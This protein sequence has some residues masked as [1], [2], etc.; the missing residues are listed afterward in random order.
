MPNRVF[1][2]MSGGVDSSVAA[3]LLLQA[4]YDVTGATMTLYRP[5]GETGDTSDVIDARAV[6]TRLGIPHR[7]YDMGDAFCHHVI[8]DFI[9]TYEDGGTP[10]PCVTCNRTIKFGALWE[11]VSEDGANAIATGRPDIGDPYHRSDQQNRHRCGNS[12]KPIFIFL[13]FAAFHYNRQS[14]LKN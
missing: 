10:N 14:I 1:A 7:T 5:H 4:G 6:C 13:F 11:A 2:A 3:Y 9:K 12:D 8:E